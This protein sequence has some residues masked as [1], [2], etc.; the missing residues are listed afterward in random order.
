MT[1]VKIKK[2]KDTKMYVIKRRLKFENY[3]TCLEGTELENTISHLG[4]NK[5]DVDIVKKDHK[6]FIKIIAT[7]RFKIGKH[8]AFT[9]EINKIA[10]SSN[11]NKRLQ[12]IDSI[13]AYTYAT[14]KGTRPGKENIKCNNTI[15]RYKK[16]IN[17]DD[18]T[19]EKRTILRNV[20]KNVI[21]EH[22]PNLSDIPDHRNRILIIGGFRSGK[23]CIA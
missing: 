5:I 13:E 22:S 3:G 20:K 16:I 17:F 9:E 14:S 23:K 10:L 4:K 18:V 8:N 21:K 19:K 15:K 6:G 7:Q 11:D 2:T 12:S 1:V